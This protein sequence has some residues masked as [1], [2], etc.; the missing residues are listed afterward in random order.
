MKEIRLHLERSQDS[1][2]IHYCGGHGRSQMMT[3]QRAPSTLT[4]SKIEPLISQSKV[5]HMSSSSPQ[6]KSLLFSLSRRKLLSITFHLFLSLTHCMYLCDK[7][8]LT[9]FRNMPRTGLSPLPH[10]EASH[11]VVSLHGLLPG[12]PVPPL[13]MTVF[14]MQQPKQSFPHKLYQNSPLFRS[15]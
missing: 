3:E 14:S 6:M 2:W 15:P 13:P 7:S 8:C 4:T 9:S 11:S 12:F 5:L 1:L 10:F